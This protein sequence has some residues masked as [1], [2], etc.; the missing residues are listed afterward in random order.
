MLSISPISYRL[1]LQNNQ[2]MP[3]SPPNLLNPRRISTTKVSMVL[4][5]K[6]VNL[7]SR[8]IL[9][10]INRMIDQF[11]TIQLRRENCPM[12]IF[13]HPLT[14]VRVYLCLSSGKSSG[15]LI[16]IQMMTER[17]IKVHHG[18]MSRFMIV[19]GI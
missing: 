11:S 4:D 15:L 19:S 18:V 16:P 2:K 7:E 17:K 9:M 6:P 14:H 5:R 3:F 12:K 13:L 10:I 1:K 8:R